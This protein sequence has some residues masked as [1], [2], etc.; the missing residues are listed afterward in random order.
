[1]V[2]SLNSPG[3]RLPHRVIPQL[4]VCEPLARPGYVIPIKS[5]CVCGHDSGLHYD[6][7]PGSGCAACKCREYERVSR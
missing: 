5:D 4:S 7:D 2:N 3:E 6:D 1:M